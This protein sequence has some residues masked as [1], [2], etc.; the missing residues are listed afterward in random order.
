MFDIRRA[1]GMIETKG[2]VGLIEATDAA[3]KA[4]DVVAVDY[5][6]TGGGLT[7][8]KIR[9]TVGAVKAAV[10]AGAMAAQRVG[11]LIAAHVIPN[12]DNGVEP[13]ITPIMPPG[14]REPAL[15]FH[16]WKKTEAKKTGEMSVK[17]DPNDPKLGEILD[18]L[19]NEGVESL[20]YNQLRYLARRIEGFP[21]TKAEIRSAGRRQLIKILKERKLIIEK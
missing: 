5:E 15:E 21:L 16:R 13:M 9:G 6:R 17:Y 14:T 10:E 4:A 19:E 12:P 2:L 7:I 1:L 20:D 8:I 11:E 18:K 3:V